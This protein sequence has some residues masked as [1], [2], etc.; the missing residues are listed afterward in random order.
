MWDVLFNSLSIIDLS[1]YL[2]IVTIVVLLFVAIF[3]NFIIRVRYNS[4][5]RELNRHYDPTISFEHEV[6]SWI[7]RDAKKAQYR[8][9]REINTQAIIETNFQRELKT[10][11]VGERFLK[12]VTG[13]LIILGLVGTFYGLTLSVGRLVILVSGDISGI[14]DIAESMTQGLAQALSGMSVAFTTSLFGIV[15]AIVMTLFN[16]FYNIPDRRAAVMVRIENYL[17]NALLG[18]EGIDSEAEDTSIS[19]QRSGQLLT[20]EI[21]GVVTRFGQSV[22]QLERAVTQFDSALEKF[23]LN[24]R[25][26]QEFNLHLKDNI[27]R[28]SL[29]FGDLTESLKAQAAAI[30]SRD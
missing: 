5:E 16:V 11:L 10:L 3:V 29:S 28:M 22:Q 15:S 24:T 25:D 19:G 7:V 8:H 23:A 12:S 9:P 14:T 6:L 18:P 26:F 30:N 2:I 21:E 1:G 4:I 13:L 17:D 20:P 27:Q